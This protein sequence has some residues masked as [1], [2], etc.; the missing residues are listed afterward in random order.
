MAPYTSPNQNISTKDF[1]PGGLF[2]VI[3]DLFQ[4]QI[5]LYA[6]STGAGGQSNDNLIN[7]IDD[8]VDDSKY[9]YVSRVPH[10]IN[11]LHVL[12]DYSLDIDWTIDMSY[13]LYGKNDS[14]TDPQKSVNI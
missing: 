6:C 5:F 7:A 8:R 12:D 1:E 3:N 11:G 9:I 13:Y 14:Q 10:N 4:K 2:A